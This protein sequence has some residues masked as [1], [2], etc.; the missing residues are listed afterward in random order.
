[1]YLI[2]GGWLH[3][4]HGLLANGI[5]VSNN[6]AT[7]FIPKCY[8]QENLLTTR[9]SPHFNTIYKYCLFLTVM[10]PQYILDLNYWVSGIYT[11]YD[12]VSDLLS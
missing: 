11:R 3:E 12:L 9:L 5:Y 2:V 1:M 8:V 6:N 4:H 7:L 10:T